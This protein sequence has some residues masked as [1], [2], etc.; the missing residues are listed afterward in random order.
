MYPAVMIPAG[1]ATI[2]IPINEDTI[3]RTLPVE[4]MGYISPYPTVVRLIVA[5]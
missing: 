1:S 2:A 5:Q 4:V 3:A